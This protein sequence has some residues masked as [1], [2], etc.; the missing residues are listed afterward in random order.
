MYYVYKRPH[1]D[2]FLESSAQIGR[3]VVFTAS[4]REYAEKVLAWLD[5]K[6][7]ISAKYFR[8][9]RGETGV[10]RGIVVCGAT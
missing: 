6:G 2:Y 7:H 10:T 9:V 1:L 8:E 3:V 5:Q 4:E